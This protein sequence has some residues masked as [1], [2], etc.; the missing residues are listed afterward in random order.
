LRLAAGSIVIATMLGGSACSPAGGSGID[1]VPAGEWGGEHVGLLVT[2]SGGRIELDCAHGTLD[3]PLAVDTDGLF[4]VP[5]TLVREGGPVR[6][7]ERPEVRS[8][9]Y[10]GR[11]R[12]RRLEL[13]LVA[14]SDHLGPY[15]MALGEPPRLL[16]CL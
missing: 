16:K 1:R 7:D 15:L 9:R 5:G 13:E 2:E 6:V 14:G 10:S 11:L 12:G 3:G 8:A 4:A